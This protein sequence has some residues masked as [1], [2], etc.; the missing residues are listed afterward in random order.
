MW[1]QGKF[2][3][4]LIVIQILYIVLRGIGMALSFLP[5]AKIRR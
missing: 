4:T 3:Y 1:E 5:L 2:W